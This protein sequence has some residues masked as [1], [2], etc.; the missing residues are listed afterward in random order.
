MA[1][2]FPFKTL[3]FDVDG[4]L[5][6]SNGAHAEA[7]TRALREFRVEITVDQIRPLI[8]M[9]SDKILPAVANVSEESE[10]GQAIARRKKELFGAQIGALQ[11]TPGARPL[12]AYLRK[13]QVELVIATSADDHEMSALLRRAG[14]DDL[15]PTRTSKDDAGTSK[16]DPDIVHAALVRSGAKPG[17]AAMVGDTPYDIEAADR[18]GIDAIALRC[19]GYWDDTRLRGAVR[20]FD[21]PLALLDHLNRSRCLR[22]ISS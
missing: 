13:Q 5:I 18:A 10:I 15:I 17:E 1:A 7:W 6:D 20:I 21:D 16:P 14:V 3:L 22:R 19:G 12:L 11:P 4:T 8:G 2:R 9:G